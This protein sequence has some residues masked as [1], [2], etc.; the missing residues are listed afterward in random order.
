[1]RSSL[2]GRW[3]LLFIGG[4]LVGCD[5]PTD[6]KVSG[7][8]T[9]QQSKQGLETTLCVSS[10]ELASSEMIQVALTVRHGESMK[11]G[12]PEVGEKWGDFFIFETRAS[13]PKLGVDGRVEERCVYTLEPDL[14]G[15]GVLTS[16]L[17]KGVGSDGE[18]VE[19]TTDPIEIR[20]VSVLAPGETEMRD[21]A[22]HARVDTHEQWARWPVALVIANVF[23]V[24]CLM[25]VRFRWRRAQPSADDTVEQDFVNLKN[26]PAQ[27]VMLRLEQAAC[28]AL[29]QRYTQGLRK[30]DFMGLS[31]RAQ[32]DGVEIAGLA[33]AVAAYERLQYSVDLP[34]EKQVHDLYTQFE[35][36]WK[37]VE[38]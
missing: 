12:L 11:V 8:S 3:L 13:P 24:G 33:E 27:E 5:R 14:P 7:G 4:L 21:I 10:D 9:H 26:A 20:V 36:V 38:G 31:E 25:V 15:V 34:D 35:I 29:A 22:P 30:V 17:V 2:I 16:L 19:M 23:F 6:D 37:E 18:E 32:Q 28:R 1:M